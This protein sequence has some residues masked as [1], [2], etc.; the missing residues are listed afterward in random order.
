MRLSQARERK[1]SVE[2]FLCENSGFLGAFLCFVI[3]PL[4]QRCKGANVVVRFGEGGFGLLEFRLLLII[5]RTQLFVILGSDDRRVINIADDRLDI[6]VFGILLEV[7]IFQFSQK[8]LASK[9]NGVIEQRC[10]YI[11][12]YRLRNQVSGDDC[13]VP[14]LGILEI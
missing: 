7:L 3:I 4:N 11:H 5:Y 2:Y 8:L 10:T 14:I 6:T 13:W 9:I 12:T 1:A